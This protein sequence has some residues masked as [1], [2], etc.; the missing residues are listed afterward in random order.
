[1][2]IYIDDTN[3]Y[4]CD[5]LIE[6]NIQQDNL[7]LKKNKIFKLYLIIKFVISYNNMKAD[8]IKNKKCLKDNTNI[9]I[10]ELSVIKKI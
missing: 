7:L 9:Y 4:L 8:C 5:S 10:N 2:S 3:T 1:M 6:I